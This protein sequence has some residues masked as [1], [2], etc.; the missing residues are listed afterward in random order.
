MSRW[1][2]CRTLGV[3]N[4]LHGAGWY[5]EDDVPLGQIFAALAVPAF[6]LLSG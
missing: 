1:C 4:L 5:G 3:L 2:D 6:R